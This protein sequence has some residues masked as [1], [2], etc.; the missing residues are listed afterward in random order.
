MINKV[1][2]LQSRILS[3]NEFVLKKI[4]YEYYK[5]DGSRHTQSREVYDRGNAAAILLYNK[6]KKTVI[7]TRQFRLPAFINGS[8]SGI[9]IEAC[10]GML[11]KESPEDG[12]IRE[13]EEETGYKIKD[14]Q[15]IFE[16]YMSPGAITELLHFFIAEY[17]ELMKVSDGGG[18]KGEEE[19]IDV[20]ELH[21]EQATGMMKSGEIKDGKTIMLLQY[22][23]LYDIL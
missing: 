15:K 20:I 23:R 9:L 4:T 3:D 10:A 8:N 13:T 22:I 11:E 2:I 19:N 17:N 6:E 7:L 1:K 16:A 21:I 14:V 18:A 5:P 12:I